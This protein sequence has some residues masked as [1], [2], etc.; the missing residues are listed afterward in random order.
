MPSMSKYLNNPPGR[1]L[2]LAITL[3]LG[4]PLYYLFNVSGREYDRFASH[5]YP[6][7]PIYSDQERLQIYISDAG[8]FTT[9]YLLCRILLAKGFATFMCMYGMPYLIHFAIIVTI[10]YL[11]HTHP[12]LPHY[13]SSE[14]DWIRG[15]LSTADRDYGFFCNTVFHHITDGHVVHHLFTKIPHYH[16]MEATRAIKPI[17]GDYYQFDDAPVYKA[18]WRC[19]K[20]CLYVHPDEGAPNQGVYWYRNKF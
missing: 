3:I 6:N 19:M 11:N 2:R 4:W 9:V 18:L 7:S 1:A 10:V 16:L 13:D 12:N 8:V 14:W 17:L 20:E 5:F 15:T